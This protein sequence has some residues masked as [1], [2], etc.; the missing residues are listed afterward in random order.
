M[1]SQDKTISD[2]QVVILDKDAKKILSHLEYLELFKDVDKKEVVKQ[3]LDTRKFEIE[4][5]WKRSTYY[6]TLIGAIFIGF[7]ATYANL[8]KGQSNRLNVVCIL[9]CLGILFSIGWY[10]VNRGSKYW[11]LNWEKHIDVVE[12]A[13]IGPLYKT[14][15]SLEHYSSLKKFLNL[16]APYPFSVSKIN[17]ILNLVVIAFWVF[18]LLHISSE[19][20]HFDFTVTGFVSFYSILYYLTVFAV[21]CLFAFG[22][23]GKDSPI[24][25]QKGKTHINFYKRGIEEGK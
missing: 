8:E 19:N 11:Q 4:L 24:S 20:L 12:T 2:V 14:T 7:F 22:R 1:G 16:T 6:W 3:I 13:I 9:N 10:F 18:L 23:T 15:I 17:Q 25:K 5:Y 21:C